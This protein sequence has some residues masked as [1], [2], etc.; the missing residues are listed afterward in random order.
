MACIADGAVEILVHTTAPSRGSDDAKYRALTR[1]YIGFEAAT[2]QK[3][4]DSPLESI[5]VDHLD[6][7]A[8]DELREDLHGSTQDEPDSAA[9]YR[10]GKDEDDAAS[11]GARSSLQSEVLDLWKVPRSL[12]SPF[13]SF[14]SAIDNADSPLFRGLV[15][16]DEGAPVQSRHSPSQLS[17]DSWRPPPSVIADSQPESDRALT[18]FSSPTRILELYLQQLDSSEGSSSH[19]PPLPEHLRVTP[20][21][22]SQ[23]TNYGLTS[24]PF[25]SS[26]LPSSPSPNKIRRPEPE[27][28][29]V[30]QDPGPPPST[31]SD[32]GVKRKRAESS[33]EEL[34][35]S[36]AP[37]ALARNPSTRP[38]DGRPP[39]QKRQ[40]IDVTVAGEMRAICLPTQ[41]N[42]LQKGHGTDAKDLAT[43][44]STP[45]MPINPTS[46]AVTPRTQTGLQ[47]PITS[48]IKAVVLET[49]TPASTATSSIWSSLLEIRPKA[50]ATSSGNLT[51]EMFITPTLQQIYNKLC[52]EKTWPAREQTRDLR[53]MERGYW[54][55]NCHSWN[56]GLRGRCWNVL[57]NY[58]GK[59]RVGWG[60]WCMRDE[61]LKS[62]RVY[63]WGIIASHIYLLLFMASEGKIRGV[64]ACW[65]DGDGEPIITMPS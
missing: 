47:T 4:R 48:A 37:A 8:G 38:E 15:P 51:A 18:V 5:E 31:D 34:R 9:S 16:R 58:I 32:L 26:R 21:P 28:M 54:S 57:G 63:C 43:I 53:P 61:A 46:T 22:G 27:P 30:D 14:A 45:P 10:P 40:R 1:A 23:S 12:E 65:V 11:T 39:V 50:P 49:S 17:S 33:S 13:L 64:G 42:V 55:V 56:E 35:I 59:D 2:R 7:P 41:P 62:I 20:N 3:L 29:A 44:K 60:V 6:G 52:S 36:S 25:E 19:T 24:D